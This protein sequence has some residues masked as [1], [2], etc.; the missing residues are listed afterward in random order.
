ML[1]MGETHL[2]VNSE[3]LKA[4]KGRCMLA[5]GKTHR[6]VRNDG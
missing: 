4:L 5:M 2:K 1:A 6:N 3:K